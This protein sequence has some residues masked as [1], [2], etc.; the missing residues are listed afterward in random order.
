MPHYGRV[1]PLTVLTSARPLRHALTGLLLAAGLLTG[2]AGEPAADR[3][4]PSS[5]AAATSDPPQE[6]TR[7]TTATECLLVDRKGLRLGVTVPAGFSVTT[8]P[9]GGGDYAPSQQ[10]NLL[11]VAQRRN[12]SGELPVVVVVV[13]G[14]G[15]GERSGADAL[16][17]S[18]RNFRQLVGSDDAGGAVAARPT[19]IAGRRGSAGG[20]ADE[21]A[22][23]FQCAGRQA[24]VPALVV[25]P[26]RAGVAGPVRRRDGRPR[27]HERPPVRDR[28][29]Q[30]PQGRR[31]L[32]APP[33]ELSVRRLCG[34]A[35]RRRSA[36]S[37]SARR[38]P[39]R[40]G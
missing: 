29:P 23:D 34:T 39:G 16:E 37:G 33:G 6:S 36:V 32:N 22:M 28:L 25:G 7:E 30:R 3:A 26:G 2:C 15:P 17:A 4:A 24:G 40:A 18:V 9:Q 8:T 38:S 31:L 20:A 35:R 1:T 19:T 21:T 11:A 14:Y 5:P 27:R 13:Y 12:A 10:V